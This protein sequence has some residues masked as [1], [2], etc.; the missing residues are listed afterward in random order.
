MKKKIK[1]YTVLVFLSFILVSCQFRNPVAPIIYG[2]QELSAQSIHTNNAN[3]LSKDIIQQRAD[4]MN[5]TIKNNHYITSSA[6]PLQPEYEIIYHKVKVGETL[7]E[8]AI[9]Y[10]QTV[11]EIIQFNALSPPYSLNKC[12]ILKIKQ[13]NIKLEN[14]KIKL[15]DNQ[16][17]T[18][19]TNFIKP[20]DGQILTRF[21][22]KTPYGINKGINIAAAQGTKIVA[23]ASG[24]VVYADY[25]ATFGYLVIVKV[26][27]KNILTS[28]AHMK[29]IILAKGSIVNQGDIIGYIGNTGKVHSYQLHFGIR[30]GKYVKDPM[31]LIHF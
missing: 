10:Q 26:Y 7:E 13:P 18:E 9:Q 25:D 22:Q 30:E 16:V 31:D 27:G 28:Y 5:N 11:H 8:I 15:E 3:I 24:K 2:Y 19:V 23:S 1:N 6:N 17:L 14:P 21:G 29:N 20:V 4:R 12:I